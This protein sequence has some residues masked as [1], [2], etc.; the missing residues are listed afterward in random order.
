M[1]VVGCYIINNCDDVETHYMNSDDD[2][3]TDQDKKR[4]DIDIEKTLMRKTNKQRQKRYAQDTYCR[5]I[6]ANTPGYAVID[7]GAKG[8]YLIK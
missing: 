1:L 5:K 8:G 7:G 2:I 6:F 4:S 3:G